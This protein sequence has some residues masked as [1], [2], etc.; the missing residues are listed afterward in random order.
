MFIPA[1]IT[2]LENNAFPLFIRKDWLDNLG[3][4]V[5]KTIEDFKKVQLLL[6]KMIRIRMEKMIPM[7]LRYQGRVTCFMTGAACTASSPHTAY[8]PVPGMTI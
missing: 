3:L 7:A 8:S 5:P 4:D 1:N 6:Q 2:S